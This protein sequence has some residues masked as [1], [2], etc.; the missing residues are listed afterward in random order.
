MIDSYIV[1]F[2][3]EG[4]MQNEYTVQSEGIGEDGIYTASELPPFTRYSFDVAPVNSAGTG[5]F[6]CSPITVQTTEAGM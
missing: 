2:G 4:G 1:L 5:P 3:P 6:T